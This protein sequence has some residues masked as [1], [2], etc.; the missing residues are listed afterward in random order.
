MIFSG[1]A[2]KDTGHPKAKHSPPRVVSWGVMN[3]CTINGWEYQK[4]AGG[5]QGE[6]RGGG[7]GGEAGGV[8]MVL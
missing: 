2:E 6:G 8:A 4:Q 5:G 3:I 7:R 1:C